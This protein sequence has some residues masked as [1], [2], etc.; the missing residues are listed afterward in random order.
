M[1]GH[2]VLASL[3]GFNTH[4][5]MILELAQTPERKGL[6]EAE[7]CILNLDW[8]IQRCR[9]LREPHDV[10]AACL[11]G[12][13]EALDVPVHGSVSDFWDA[14]G[15]DEVLSRVHDDPYFSEKMA[16]SAHVQFEAEG[17]E[18]A[19]PSKNFWQARTRWSLFSEGEL[20]GALEDDDGSELLTDETLGVWAKVVYRKAGRAGLVLERV[21]FSPNAW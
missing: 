19:K 17:F 12:A 14:V 8:G 18:V 21:R 5:A 16:E 2:E 15:R 3:F 20:Q 10:A 1:H 4:T 13:K 9:E 11:M 6:F 7:H